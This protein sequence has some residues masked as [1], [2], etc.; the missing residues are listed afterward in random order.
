M[1]L[2][3]F[4]VNSSIFPLNNQFF[5]KIKVSENPFMCVA[6]KWLKNNQ[7]R[8]I[9]QYRVNIFC[10]FFQIS[11]ENTRGVRPLVAKRVLHVIVR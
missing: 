11:S 3:Q 4:C 6:A 10:C 1:I 2:I 7:T 8:V 9:L 5:A